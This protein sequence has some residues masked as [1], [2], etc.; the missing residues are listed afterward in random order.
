[1][2]FT[3]NWLP[4][5]LNDLA[6]LWLNDQDPAAVTHAANAI[7]KMLEKDPLGHGEGRQGN[8]RILFEAPLVVLFDVDLDKR[9]VTVFDVW[10]WPPL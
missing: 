10:R 7:D 6:D 5:P 3:V 4:S 8:S 2:D 9:E 1:M